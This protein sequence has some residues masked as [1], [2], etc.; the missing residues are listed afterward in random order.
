MSTRG[1]K[2]YFRSSSM[3]LALCNC[4]EKMVIG[5]K[6]NFGLPSDSLNIL[7]GSMKFFSMY[8]I[9]PSR[10]S[11]KVYCVHL[12]GGNCY[13]EGDCLN[14]GIENQSRVLQLL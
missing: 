9:T 1:S 3:A 7:S 4:L 13:R 14:C 10:A 11:E 12:V 5:T 6:T 2:P 8:P